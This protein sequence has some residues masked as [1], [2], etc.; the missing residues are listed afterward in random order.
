MNAEYVCV[1]RSSSLKAT[2]RPF[3]PKHTPIVTLNYGGMTSLNS[4]HLIERNKRRTNAKQNSRKHKF[5]DIVFFAATAIFPI[6]FSIVNF[7]C[8]FH[9]LT[10]NWSHYFHHS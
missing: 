9:I 3:F 6:F 2:I 5:V 10:K 4:L 8:L 1:G 7:E